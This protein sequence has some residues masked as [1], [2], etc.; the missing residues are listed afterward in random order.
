MNGYSGKCH[1]KRRNGIGNNMRRKPGSGKLRWQLTRNL[2]LTIVITAAIILILTISYTGEMRRSI[3]RSYIEK[4]A[5]TALT[6]FNLATEPVIDGLRI[7]KRWCE[8]GLIEIDNP[9]QLIRN[10]IPFLEQLPQTS[11][12]IIV[13]NKGEEFF[14]MRDSISWITRQ[15]N[16]KKYKRKT[17]VQ[18][19]TSDFQMIDQNLV[20]TTLDP[21]S[22][23]WYRINMTDTNDDEIYWTNPYLFEIQKIPGIS[24]SLRAYPGMDTSNVY[25]FT[26][27]LP[28]DDFY[29]MVSNL[30]SSENGHTFLFSEEGYLFDLSELN[31]TIP[32]DSG[33][34]NVFLPIEGLPETEVTQAIKIWKSNPEMTEAVIEFSSG[35]DNWWCG[36]RLLNPDGGRLLMGSIIPDRDLIGQLYDLR[37]IVFASILLIVAISIAIIVSFIRIYIRKIRL[38]PIARLDHQKIESDIFE[39]I[40]SGESKNIEFKSTMRMN[41]KTGKSGKEIEQAW[42]KSVTAFMNTDGGILLIGVDD[43]GGIVGNEA[44]EFENDDKCRL[45]FKNLIKQHIGLEFSEFIHMDVHPIENKKI[46]LIEVDK[47]PNPAFLR[48]KE[49]EDFYIR[50]GPSSV[51]LPVSKVLSYLAQQTKSV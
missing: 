2:V 41:L 51:K 3:S 38:L 21:H 36:F 37:F 29:N 17:L 16:S 47:S 28:L 5:Q 1:G 30:R 27:D 49:E 11:A 9:S 12:L 18:R 44:D 50:S 31:K 35:G 8:A 33:N 39:I 43:D 24:A 14:I 25:I 7:A 13:S 40:K 20:Q 34:V 23:E 46:V 19:W 10:F 26:Y 42:L 22:R 6:E 4:T 32:M 48:M 15:I 45:H